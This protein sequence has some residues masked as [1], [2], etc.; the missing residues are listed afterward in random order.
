MTWKLCKYRLDAIVNNDKKRWNN[1][2]CRCKCKDLVDKGRWDNGL[3]WN[4][5]IC[6]CDKSRDIGQYLGYQICKCRKK[7]ISMLAEEFSEDVNG[8]KI[9]HNG[10][11]NDFGK[12][13]NSCTIYIVLFVILF[14][15]S[16]KICSEFLLLLVLKKK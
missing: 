14:I 6:E 1:G 5:S 7:L 11:L 9:F 15:I 10:T 13:S 4:L 2:K 8:N 3:I 16:I 12:V